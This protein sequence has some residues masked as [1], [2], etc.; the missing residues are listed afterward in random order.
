MEIKNIKIPNSII[1]RIIR[2]APTYTVSE[3]YGRTGGYYGDSD[4]YAKSYKSICIYVQNGLEE[5]IDLFKIIAKA[6]FK[7]QINN[8]RKYPLLVFGFGDTKNLQHENKY[9]DLGYSNDVYNYNKIAK[10]ISRISGKRTVGQA[11]IYE[12]FPKTDVRSL[13][14]GKIRIDKDDL[15]I[16]IGKKNEVFF[17]SKLKLKLNSQIKKHILFVELYQGNIEFHFKNYKPQFIEEINSMKVTNPIE[18]L[19]KEVAKNLI[20]MYPD[21]DRGVLIFPKLRD[22]NEIRISEQEARFTFANEVTKLGEYYYAV[23]VPTRMR[24]SDF[25]TDPKVYE[26]GKKEGRSGAV[27][28][29]LFQ[30]NDTRIPFINIEFKSGQP[31]QPSITKD[32]LKLAFEPHKYG[33]F[34]HTLK[35]SKDD[36]LNRLIEKINKA[37]EIIKRTS[38]QKF[39]VNC[40]TIFIFIVILGKPKQKNRYLGYEF[41]FLKKDILEVKDFS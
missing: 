4:E 12:L 17:N 32:I 2:E 28:L 26:V 29:S 13:Y 38:G 35:N 9:F 6:I 8:C 34:F 40:S 14:H 16:I 22:S 41:D 11:I 18:N 24:Y 23:E 20:S 33:V 37:F 7:I 30:K 1:R 15:L 5:K 25:S 3:N 39:K 31:P 10:T 36:S 27:D 19:C 21:S